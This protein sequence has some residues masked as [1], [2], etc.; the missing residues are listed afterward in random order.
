MYSEFNTPANIL[1]NA[2]DFSA[3]SEN[4]ISLKAIKKIAVDDDFLS[5]TGEPIEVTC[6]SD[7]A[8]EMLLEWNCWTRDLKRHLRK[9]CGQ[10]LKHQITHVRHLSFPSF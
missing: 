9:T 6:E 5:F 2:Y 1:I 4:W 3:K 10:H 7:G 8:P